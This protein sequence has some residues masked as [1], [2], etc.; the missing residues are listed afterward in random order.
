MTA[1]AVL[2]QELCKRRWRQH[3]AAA[4]ESSGLR[5]RYHRAMQRA[6]GLGF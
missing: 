1:P 2:A 5:R 3:F 6:W 4:G